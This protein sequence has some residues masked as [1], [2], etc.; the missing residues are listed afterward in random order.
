M[1]VSNSPYGLC[2]RKATL[3]ER[4]NERTNAHALSP[5]EIKSREVE[6]GSH[7][8]ID[9]LASELV[10]N[11]CFSDNV[12]VVLFRTAVQTAISEAHKLLR[13]GVVL[14]LLFWRWRDGLFGLYGSG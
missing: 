14:T 12:F 6:L 10:L 1:A 4:T 2:G 7:S 11:S 9:R 3:N 13:S 5:G 8:W